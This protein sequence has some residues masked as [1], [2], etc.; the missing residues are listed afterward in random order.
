MLDEML[1]FFTCL[2]KIK[3]TSKFLFITIEPPATILSKA[4][5]K[6]IPL[7]NMLIHAAS[8]NE[9]PLYLSLSSLS[10]YFIKPCY[11]KKASSP[12][13]TAEILGMGIPII[14]NSGIGDV[15]ELLSNSGIGKLIRYFNF[16]EYTS[17]IHQI[18]LL[19]AIEKDKIVTIATT[20]FSLEKGL[21][22][23][24][25]VYDQLINSNP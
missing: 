8:R 14:T 17:V 23:Y 18:P 5:S 3:P 11:S 6:G 22:S 12:T 21:Q 25:S 4:A 1:D 10:I 9:V 7:Q 15:D 13:K 20:Y 24:Q 16:D 2:I 19:L